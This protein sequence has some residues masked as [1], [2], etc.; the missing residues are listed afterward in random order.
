[1]LKFAFEC[2]R[3]R[4]AAM[5]TEAGGADIA[6]QLDAAQQGPVIDQVEQLAYQIR[7]EQS[8][9]KDSSAGNA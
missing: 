4:L 2:L 9:A 8:R 5:L 1:M 7:E 3:E 6:A